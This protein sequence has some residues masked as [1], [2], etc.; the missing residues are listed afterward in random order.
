MTTSAPSNEAPISRVKV[1]DWPT[2]IFHWLLV[3]HIPILWLTAREEMMDAHRAAGSAVAGLIIF[4]TAWGFLGSSTA[5]FGNFVKGPR[6]ILSY[7]RGDAPDA[8]GHNPLGGWSIIA[9]L[10]LL[11]IQVL[12][13]LFATD[14]NGLESGPLAIHVSFDT[15][16]EA[17]A[18]HQ[19]SFDLLLV[20]I[21][22]HLAAILFYAVVR[23]RNLV[24][25]MFTGRTA[26]ANVAPMEEAGWGRLAIAMMLGAATTLW[27][28]L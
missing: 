3:I 26:A 23:R 10:A 19:T 14:V 12:L 22:L 9:M 17:A 25:P 16:R 13:G 2:R 20:L 15:A 27:L 6:A 1:W 28:N 5:R 24:T 18:W 8:L 7:L 21:A 4:R 11:A